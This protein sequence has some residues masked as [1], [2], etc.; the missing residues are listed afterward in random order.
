MEALLTSL[1]SSQWEL[2]VRA[3]SDMSGLSVEARVMMTSFSM[4]DL[5][6]EK[7]R[8]LNVVIFGNE[9]F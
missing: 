2:A 8:D 7:W 1:R 3:I 6:F 9:R 5:G 4:A